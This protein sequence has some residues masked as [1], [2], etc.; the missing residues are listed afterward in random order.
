MVAWARNARLDDSVRHG[1][2]CGSFC[3]FDRRRSIRYATQLPIDIGIDS[4]E[5]RHSEDHLVAAKGSDEEYFF[6]GNTR[7]RKLENGNAISV[8]EFRSI[9]DGNVDRSAWYRGES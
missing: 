5:P 2:F 9:G 4:F 8:K 6:V 7:D 3:G 1:N